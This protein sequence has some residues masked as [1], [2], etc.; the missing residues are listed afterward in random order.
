MIKYTHKENQQMLKV[1]EAQAHG[2]GLLQPGENLEY[3]KGNTSY[4][5]ATE[6]GVIKVHE[7]GQR[8]N[9]T[10]PVWVPEFGYKDGP[11]TVGR[12]LYAVSNVIYHQFM[13]QVNA[14]HEERKRKMDY[15]A[16]HTARRSE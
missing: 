6:I 11:S 1:M 5:H 3:R 2:I 16:E 14:E 10:R 15:L 9:V 7:D 12:V 13:T 4:G 8:E